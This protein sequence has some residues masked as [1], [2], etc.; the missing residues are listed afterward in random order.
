MTTH[1]EDNSNQP[2]LPLLHI[3]L[4]IL[5]YCVTNHV[6]FTHYEIKQ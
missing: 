4:I 6:L 3:D 2:D 1:C 5:A